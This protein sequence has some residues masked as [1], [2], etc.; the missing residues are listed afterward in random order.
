MSAVRIVVCEGAGNQIISAYRECGGSGGKQFQHGSFPI[1]IADSLAGDGRGIYVSAQS[2]LTT[3][4]QSYFVH[5]WPSA[6]H[7]AGNACA[8]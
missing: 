5:I 6:A 1:A 7:P 8:T 2:E 3:A 4:C